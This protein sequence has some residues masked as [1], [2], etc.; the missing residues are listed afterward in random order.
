MDLLWLILFAALGLASPY[1][2][3]AERELLA[4]LALFQCVEPR[5]SFFS[6]PSGAI[7]SVVV[8]L[9]LGYLLVGVTGAVSSSYYV[10]LLAPVVA[11]VTTM[12]AAGFA[13]VSALSCGA[14]LSFLLLLDW[15]R[16]QLLPTDVRELCLRVL[17]FVVLAILM[18]QVATTVRRQS[19]QYL[20]TAEQLAAANRSL[21]E[22]ERAARRSERLAAIGQRTAHGRAGA[23]VTQSARHD[24][25]VR[26]NDGKAAANG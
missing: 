24:E 2:N 19:R 6:T 10:I 3:S 9:L 11:A 21:A 16:Y 13:L 23:R 15:N 7:I 25:G 14:Y 1:R 17:L 26:R 8:K 22:A 12:G 4:A 20:E 5:V 18:H